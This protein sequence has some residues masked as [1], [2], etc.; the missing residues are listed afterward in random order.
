[1]NT[2]LSNM[3]FKMELRRW[4]KKR[5]QSV[6]ASLLGVPLDTY[7]NW[8]QGRNTPSLLAMVSV[9]VIMGKNR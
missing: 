2:D 4:R 5:T 6:A 3:P 1:M 8:E 7:R 9:L